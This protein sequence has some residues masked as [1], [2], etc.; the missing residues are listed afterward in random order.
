MKKLSIIILIILFVFSLGAAESK[1]K[2]SYNEE[3][4]I[5]IASNISFPKAINALQVMSEQYEDKKIVNLSTYSG[6]VGIPLNFVYWKQAL[7]IL[8]EHHDLVLQELP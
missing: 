3:E 1:A 2:E 8:V 6:P 5:S 7:T 4:L